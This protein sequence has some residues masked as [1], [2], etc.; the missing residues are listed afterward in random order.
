MGLSVDDFGTGQSSLARLADLPADEVKIDRS[1]ISNPDHN[2][3][4][5]RV[6]WGVVASAQRIGLTVVAEGV[7]QEAELRAHTKLGCHRAQD[8][9]F[10]RPVPASAVDVF[11]RSERNWLIGIRATPP[12][13]TRSKVRQNPRDPQ[14]STL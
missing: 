3:A 14:G 1:F 7:E 11:L 4:R 10:S 8:L 13:P 6:V 2:E 5:R 9:L 12:E